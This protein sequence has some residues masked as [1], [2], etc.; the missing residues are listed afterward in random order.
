MPSLAPDKQDIS[1]LPKWAQ[2]RIAT[3][4]REAAYWQARALDG[5]EGS[6]TAVNEGMKLKPLE[7]GAE[8][9]F[10]L[11]EHWVEHIDV[12]IDKD[13]LLQLMGGDGIAI[14]PSS[15]NVAFV[16]IARSSDDIRRARAEAKSLPATS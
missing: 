12:R 8:I 16:R 15:S 1:K 10:Q 13:G 14:Y 6:N 4:E 5:P 11:G 7:H 3:L 2:Q 9:R